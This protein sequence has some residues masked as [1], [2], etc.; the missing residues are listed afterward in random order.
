[1]HCLNADAGIGL[2]VDRSRLGA[3]RTWSADQFNTDLLSHGLPVS[4]SVAGGPANRMDSAD[5]IYC[6]GTRS[7][8]MGAG[9]FAGLAYSADTKWSCSCWTKHTHAH[10]S[11]TPI[12]YSC[13]TAQDSHLVG[14]VLEWRCWNISV[15]CVT[16]RRERVQGASVM[17]VTQQQQIPRRDRTIAPSPLDIC[18]IVR[19]RA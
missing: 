3:D 5:D 13:K 1:M 19:V 4:V 10:Y 18:P 16:N 2:N 14:S 15:S 6:E 11:M 12:I 17:I 9:Q 7:T 8:R